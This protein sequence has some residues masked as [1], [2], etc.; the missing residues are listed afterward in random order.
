[1]HIYACTM[2]VTFQGY[3]LK[4]MREVYYKI[5]IKISKQFNNSIMRGAQQSCLDFCCM[6][7]NSFIS[8]RFYLINNTPKGANMYYTSW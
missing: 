8:K 2:L 3:K 1:M 5:Y 7:C 6:I 4:N